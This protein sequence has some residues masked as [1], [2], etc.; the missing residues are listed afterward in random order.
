M[1]SYRFDAI[2]SEVHV[3][4]PSENG[5]AIT[6]VRELFAEWESG[7]SRFLPNSEFS[8]LNRRSGEPVVV[9]RPVFDAIWSGVAAA[10]ATDGIFDPTLHWGARAGGGP[11]NRQAIATRPRGDRRAASSLPSGEV[12]LPFGA[13]FAGRATIAPVDETGRE[14]IRIDGALHGATRDHLEIYLRGVPFDDGGVAM[15]QSRVRMGT[16]TALYQGEIVGL[17][18]SELVA[19]VRSTTRRVR[20]VISLTLA[21]DGSVSGSV[22]GSS[23]S[24]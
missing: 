9:G 13:R 22:Q 15:E 6:S 18:G 1:H 17:R 10:R 3:L 2:G 12:R 7:L 24:V 5:D 11:G 20:L 21:R 4:L 14:T 8:Q 23:A 16:T 19:S